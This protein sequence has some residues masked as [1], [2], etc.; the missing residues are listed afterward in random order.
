MLETETDSEAHASARKTQRR[1]NGLE[2]WALIWPM[3]WSWL[4][5]LG[6][7]QRQR[8]T[9]RTI[10]LS[11]RG[12]RVSAESPG[13]HGDSE[14]S[15]TEP[16]AFPGYKMEPQIALSQIMTASWTSLK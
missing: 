4:R 1:G 15:S 2:S 3:L 14:L 5:T 11:F 8:S 9:T 6:K 10:A 13:Q 7:V 12:P 16:V